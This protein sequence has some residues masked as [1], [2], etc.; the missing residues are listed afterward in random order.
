MMFLRNDPIQTLY[1]DH[2]IPKE[3]VSTTHINSSNLSSQL[4]FGPAALWGL[5]PPSKMKPT[6][7]KAANLSGVIELGLPCVQ[8]L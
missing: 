8:F 4:L 6:S 5:L 2:S 1:K 7:F 3:V